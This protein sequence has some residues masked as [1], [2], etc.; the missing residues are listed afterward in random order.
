MS[1]W[2]YILIPIAVPVIFLAI[3][4]YRYRIYGEDAQNAPQRELNPDINLEF[5]RLDLDR[6]NEKIRKED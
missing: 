3:L 4:W 5:T 6:R 2:P 1:M